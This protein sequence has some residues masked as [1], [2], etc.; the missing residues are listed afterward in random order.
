[1]TET[2]EQMK[3]R[4][5]KEREA[6][7]AQHMAGRERLAI[8]EGTPVADERWDRVHAARPTMRRGW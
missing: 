7:A 5:R 2:R 6:L 4:H 3:A 1:M 8:L